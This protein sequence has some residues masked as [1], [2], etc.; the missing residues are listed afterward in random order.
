MQ[1]GCV[2]TV[3]LRPDVTDLM[4]LCRRRFARDGYCAVPGI[5]AVPDAATLARHHEMLRLSG[6]MYAGA[7]RG[8]RRW[9][10][11]DEQVARLIQRAIAPT[12][13]GIAAVE[14]EPSETYTAI[15]EAGA[16]PPAEGDPARREFSVLLW[17]ESGDALFCRGAAP[18]RAAAQPPPGSRTAVV[19]SYVRA[20]AA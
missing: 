10:L 20:E 16:E 6:R 3:Q 9:V 14:V 12:L 15:Y 2:Y 11:H 13:A 19:L 8:R 4:G 5:L 7:V 1:A 18:P 17:V